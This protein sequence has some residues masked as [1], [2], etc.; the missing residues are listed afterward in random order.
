MF[1]QYMIGLTVTVIFFGICFFLFNAIDS[2]PVSP[3]LTLLVGLILGQIIGTVFSFKSKAIDSQQPETNET[4]TLYVGNLPFKTNRYELR[5]LF[6]PYGKIYSARIMI[7]KT[8]R[9]PRG[10]GFVEMDKKGAAK[11]IA[12]LNGSIMAG[13]NLKVNEANERS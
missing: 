11:A 10:Y 6:Q 1:K 4:Q 3:M 5:E 12:S 9:K 8:T 7:D 2:G 13:R